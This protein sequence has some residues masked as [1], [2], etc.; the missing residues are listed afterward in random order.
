MNLAPP[1]V[2]FFMWLAM[3]E[4]LNTK[5]LL[6]KKGVLKE[7]QKSCTFCADEAESLN[8]ALLACP[9]SWSI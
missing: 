5:E 8:H 4:K 9:I 2:E 7:D 1:K 3:L 6:C